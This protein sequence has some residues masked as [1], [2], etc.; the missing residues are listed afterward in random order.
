MN[1][2]PFAVMELQDIDPCDEACWDSF[3][4]PLVVQRAVARILAAHWAPVVDFV[5]SSAA[6]SLGLSVAPRSLTCD[7]I[8][9]LRVVDRGLLRVRF[10]DTH[11]LRPGLGQRSRTAGCS[12]AAITRG[13][14]GTFVRA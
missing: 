3:E 12:V 9:R 4:V 14:V 1:E 7:Q 5:M 13:G 8:D 6:S 10:C 11:R 2:L